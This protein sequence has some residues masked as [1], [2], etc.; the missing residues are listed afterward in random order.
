MRASKIDFAIIT[1]LKVERTAV[2]TRLDDVETVQIEGEPL[3]YYV[4]TVAVPG[5]T[6]KFRVVVTQL[7]EMGVS[8]AAIATTRVI[9]QWNPR[10]V[11]MVGIA[12]GVEGKAK[13]GDVLVSQFAYYYE[14]GKATTAGFESRG[15]QFNSDLLLFGRAQHYEAAEWRDEIRST[16]PD[17]DGEEATFPDVHFGPIA[18]GEQVIANQEVLD[19]IKAQCPKMIGVAMEGAGAAKG[20]LSSGSPPRYLEIRGVS[21]YAGP[22]KND[23]WHEYAANAAAAFTIGFLRAR[24]FPPGPPPEDQTTQTKSTA[25]LVLTAQSL[26]SIPDQ[27]ILPALD[28]ATQQGELEFVH[29]DFTDLVKNKIFASPE[30]AASRLADPQGPLIGAVARRA[31]ARIV[32][33]GLCAIPPVVLAG[34]IV[35]DRRKVSLFDFHPDASNW[36][37]PGTED[38]FMSLKRSEMPKRIIT[39][40]GEVMIRMPITYPISK[41]DTDALNLNPRLTIDLEHPEIGRSVVRSE[42]QVR[43]YGRSFRE[44]LDLIRKCMPA[45][46]RV[47][48]FYA[49]PMALAFHIGQQISENI[50]PPVVVWNFSRK[51]EWGI[52][53][54]AALS[55]EPC[56]LR[57]APETD[58]AQ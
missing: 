52:D 4:G 17:A 11:L 39:T 23:G 48:L 1:A 20:A 21:D 45:C 43:E 26:R 18:C 56:I 40:P 41:A 13:L 5:D 50:H 28:Q 36:I 27:E 47:H 38:G 54:A 7:L 8:D 2:V 3:T 51:Y 12:G 44:T 33:H 30:T 57:P 58:G 53:L 29:L 46:R 31:D 15:R 10:N 22:D 35:T 6:K 24:P 25:T 34:H 37:W 16:R 42:D 9:N 32:F 55:G 19:A 14:P 49:G